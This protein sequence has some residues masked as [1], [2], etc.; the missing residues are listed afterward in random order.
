MSKGEPAVSTPLVRSISRES[1][2][3]TDLNHLLLCGSML[4]SLAPV[5]MSRYLGTWHRQADLPGQAASCH[6]PR[7]KRT[8]WVNSL[9]DHGRVSTHCSC[10][11][12]GRVILSIHSGLKYGVLLVPAGS[13]GC[14]GRYDGR[15]LPQRTRSAGPWPNVSPQSGM[16]IH[17]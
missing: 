6:S 2:K 8:L 15:C 7:K 4:V 3:R 12:K 14:C 16:A 1:R 5:T 10:V 11:G 17:D 13:T 9:Q